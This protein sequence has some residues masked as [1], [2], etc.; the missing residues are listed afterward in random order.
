[1][2]DSQPPSHR[3][4]EAATG[5]AAESPEAATQSPATSYGRLAKRITSWT[6]NLLATAIVLLVCLGV[7]H[8]LLDWSGRE[9]P[10]A[11][12]AP[13]A[14]YVSSTAPGDVE[15][16]VADGMKRLTIEGERDAVRSDLRRRIE[17]ATRQLATDGSARQAVAGRTPSPAETRLLELTA[18]RPAA[19][20]E[21]GQWELHEFIGTFP[22]WVGFV[23]FPADAAATNVQD[24]DS[25]APA[26]NRRLAAWGMAVPAGGDRWNL[27]LQETGAPQ[28]V[29]PRGNTLDP[30]LPEGCRRTLALSD[31]RGERLIGFAGETAVDNCRRHFD[32][33]AQT[34]DPPQPLAWHGVP[35]NWRAEVTLPAGSDR[36]S[37][38]IAGGHRIQLQLATDTRG[39]VLGLIAIAPP[40]TDT[41]EQHP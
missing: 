2:A 29:T 34:L 27:Y 31:E 5:A 35:G 38:A 20:A 22:L 13:S 30:P 12:V 10:L 4:P 8:T 18:N 36:S 26:T 16:P 40:S 3:S 32:R 21:P 33:W 14:G 11:S 6:S 24:K 7:G 19:A 23:H 9:E 28:P 17:Q 39:K 1:M 25:A 41:E 37:A 15:F